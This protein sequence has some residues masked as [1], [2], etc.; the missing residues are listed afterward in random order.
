MN[1]SLE[2]TPSGIGLGRGDTV[3]SSNLALPPAGYGWDLSETD[4]LVSGALR[5]GPSGT[6]L[7]PAYLDLET[8]SSCAILRA[9]PLV[10]PPLAEAI[11][12]AYQ[13][14]RG[15]TG[16]RPGQHG[17]HAAHLRGPA[18]LALDDELSPALRLWALERWI[19]G[20]L[21]EHKGFD[22]IEQYT[23]LAS[24]ALT[25]SWRIGISPDR[26]CAYSSSA[27]CWALWDAAPVAI[28]S[29]FVAVH[30]GCPWEINLVKLARKVGGRLEGRT[31]HCIPP[32]DLIQ[33]L[34]ACGL[35]HGKP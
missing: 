8:L 5:G 1:L 4:T 17:L 22:L 21:A 6:D 11:H 25:P 10:Q 2:P 7:C 32:A 33:T 16:W 13:H 26:R 9:G 20:E 18:R 3:C 31:V 35:P 24:E 34:R 23:E 30:P 14:E 27:P 15:I 19:C 12:R 28:G 29:T